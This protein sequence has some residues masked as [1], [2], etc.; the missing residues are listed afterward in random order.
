ML[1]RRYREMAAK[2]G[3][4]ELYWFDAEL[5]EEGINEAKEIGETWHYGMY[6]APLPHCFGA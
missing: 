4:E 3:D 2:T 6:V 1:I 5:T